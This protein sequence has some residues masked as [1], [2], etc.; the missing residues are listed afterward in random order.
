MPWSVTVRCCFAPLGPGVHGSMAPPV[1][2]YLTAFS[3]RFS[4]SWLMR[5]RVPVT[6]NAGRSAST[7]HGCSGRCCAALRRGG[8]PRRPSRGFLPRVD[9]LAMLGPRGVEQVRARGRATAWPPRRSRSQAAGIGRRPPGCADARRSMS[10]ACAIR[11]VS[12]GLRSC[13]AEERKSSFR[14]VVF[15]ARSARGAASS[16][17]ARLS[18]MTAAWSARSCTST[19]SSSAKIGARGG[20]HG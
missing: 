16:I 10:C 4:T 1:G 9:Q 14:R 6:G 5:M 13:A 11:V 7:W 19:R 17:S 15:L 8:A 2:L 12:S 3:T 20:E 18:R